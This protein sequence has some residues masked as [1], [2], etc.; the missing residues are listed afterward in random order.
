MEFIFS[1]FL[2]IK[3]H[4]LH[5]IQCF[6]I[7]QKNIKKSIFVCEKVHFKFYKGVEKCFFCFFSLYYT[8]LSH[9]LSYF[10]VILRKMPS[11]PY[12]SLI[13][14]LIK[15]VKNGQK[16]VKNFFQYKPSRDIIP[17]PTCLFFP[18]NFW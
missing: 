16:M 17:M 14:F 2:R 13:K 18:K 11:N 7:F 8:I 10:N 3:M 15:W 9:N 12:F 4:F 5:I 6:R 1:R